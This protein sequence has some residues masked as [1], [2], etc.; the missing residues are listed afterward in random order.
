MVLESLVSV[1]KAEK[2]Y[3]TMFFYGLLFVSVAILLSL[4]IFHDQSSMV[5]VFLVV[6]ACVPLMYNTIKH[7]ESIDIN[8]AQE[9][10][11][12]REHTKVLKFLMFLFIGFIVAFSLWFTFL[13]EPTTETLFSTQLKTIGQINSKITG[14]A[15]SSGV[16]IQIFLNNFK[17]LL[18]CIFFSFFYGAGAIFILTWNASVIGAA[19]GTFIREKLSYFGSYFAVIPI[20]LLRYMTHGFFE[21]LAYFIGGLAGGI[22]S[23]AIIRH[24]TENKKFKTVLTDSM[25]LIILAVIILIIASLI[26]VYITPALF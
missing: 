19:M 12:L 14:D 2:N 9:R 3:K 21:I 11:L 8:T 22:I 20:A 23:I 26:E 18:F 24:H 1:E 7:E 5:M 25:D 6:I 13:P 17:V 4:W 15:I 10:T 16:L